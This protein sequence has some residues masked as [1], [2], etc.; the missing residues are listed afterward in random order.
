MIPNEVKPRIALNT[1]IIEDIIGTKVVSFRCP[2]LFGDTHVVN[3]LEELG[4]TADSSYPMYFY[5]ERL[6]PYHPSI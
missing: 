4:Y 5:K 1:K 3:A 2:R 6:L